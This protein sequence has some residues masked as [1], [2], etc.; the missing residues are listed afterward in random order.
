MSRDAFQARLLVLSPLEH[1][2]IQV[3][4]KLSG[5]GVKAA[6]TGELQDAGS[7]HFLLGEGALFAL[8]DRPLVAIPREVVEREA[9][10]APAV[11]PTRLP[12]V[13]YSDT[14]VLFQR[15]EEGS[16]S[17]GMS[18][19]GEDAPIAR[20]VALPRGSSGARE[21]RAHMDRSDLRVRDGRQ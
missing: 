18:S 20:P 4:F 2:A 9:R 3:G 19:D 21:M 15:L 12:Q 5:A 17:N 1:L 11:R 16:L 10:E 7:L 8:Q 14:K 13:M 6:L